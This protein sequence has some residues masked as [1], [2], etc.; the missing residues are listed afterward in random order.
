MYLPYRRRNVKVCLY[1]IK[2]GTLQ[3]LIR[4]GN[5]GQVTANYNYVYEPGRN[6]LDKVNHNGALFTDYTYNSIGQMIQMTEADKTY[7]LTYTASGKVKEIRDASDILIL[8]YTYDGGGQ[9]LMKTAYAS[10]TVSRNTYYVHDPSG[11]ILA[12]YEQNLPG[13]TVSLI[14]Q[15]I[16]GTGRIGVYRGNGKS[17]YEVTDHLGNVRAVI[18]TPT[19][20]TE[21]ATMESELTEEPPFKNI[22]ATRVPFVTANHTGTI[23][24]VNSNEVV[25]LNSA[26]PAGPTR[27]L[28]VTPGDKIDLDVWAYY[29]T[30]D[31]SGSISDAI[32][33]NAVASAFGGVAGGPAKPGR[34]SIM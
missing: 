18:G 2:T 25:R 30:G 12:I 10:G 9:L 4:K 33:L 16:Y 21:T 26:A 6:Q 7:K 1:T 32:L 24:N 5:T 27:S 28:A 19:V 3:S 34:S 13:S 8:K 31:Y 14:E 22:T 11:N 23:A 20:E 29:E 15:P 17:L